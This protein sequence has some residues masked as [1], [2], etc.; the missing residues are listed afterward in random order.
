MLVQG[1]FKRTNNMEN[2]TTIVLNVDLGRPFELQCPPRHKVY[3][4]KIRWGNKRNTSA[5][6]IEFPVSR[7]V[8]TKT[9]GNLYFAYVI[10]QDVEFISGIGGVRCTIDSTTAS[11]SRRTVSNL[12]VLR[13]RGI[14]KLT[15][16]YLHIQ[17]SS[18]T[19]SNFWHSNWIKGQIY[20]FL[21]VFRYSRYLQWE[22]S[23]GFCYQTKRCKS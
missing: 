17:G 11:G 5:P 19:Y 2:G 7:R 21:D 15:M 22:Q 23:T 12:F 16:Y 13:K 18:S 4:E 9:N 10:Q 3:P 1:N 8:W 20:F 14:R 6:Y